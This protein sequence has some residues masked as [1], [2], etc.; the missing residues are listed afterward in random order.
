MPSVKL[1]LLLLIGISGMNSE[2]TTLLDVHTVLDQE[3]HYLSAFWP[4]QSVV[5]LIGSF[6]NCYVLYALFEERRS[7]VTSVNAM[8]W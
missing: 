6:L 2:N 4:W 5:G 7:L 3:K 1:I 8:I